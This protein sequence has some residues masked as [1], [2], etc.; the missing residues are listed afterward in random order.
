MNAAL[1]KLFEDYFKEYM[2]LIPIMATF[3]GIHKYNHLY[4]NYLSEQ[5][6][7]KNKIFYKKYLNLIKKINKLDLSKKDIHHINVLK[8]RLEGD[9]ESY[10][11]PFDLLP[12]DH[13][14]N[15]IIDHIETS[16]G[17][18]FLPLKTNKDFKNL[19]SQ[20]RSFF[21]VIDSSI[22]KM[23][24]GISKD[25]VFSKIIM[26]KT[27]KQLKNVIKTKNYLVSPSKI[28][29]NL[30][31]EYLE[32]MDIQFTLKIK[33][34]IK[35]LENEY[36]D[37]C[38]DDL[39]YP[40]GPEVYKYL[41]KNYT[42]LKNPNIPKIHK[43]GL[44]EVERINGEIDVLFLTNNMKRPTNNQL[45]K[46]TFKSKSNI[47]NDYE[48]VRKIINEKIIPKYFNIKISHDYL[49][50]KVPEFKEDSD[51]GAYYRMCSI[52]NKRKGTFFLNMS[53]VEDHQ[54]YSTLSL[55]LHEGNPGHHFQLTY[56]NDL[57][58]PNF[59]SYCGDEI[60]YVE[61]WALYAESL[62]HDFFKDSKDEKDI[63]FRFGCYNYEMMRACRLVVDTGIHYYGW[64]FK[65]CFDYM[66][67]NTTFSKKEIENEIYRYVAYAGQALAYK[68]GELKFKEL[69]E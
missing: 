59:I 19:I 10:K 28:P 47:I 40:G 46:M 32:V 6:I 44:D 41:V 1:K 14:N 27:L 15:F 3:I 54:T 45:R 65:K 20:T 34:M 31:D 25:I 69:K 39:R 12:I 33:K 63:M 22:C 48:R 49:L 61:G 13:F 35:F 57:D 67:Q 62:A 8:S 42:T 58:L 2:E 21:E 51:A 66:K 9:L 4:P 38:S 16:S 30:K 56:V 50:K 43:L 53:D 64:D 52:D 60:A 18:S 29:N 37:N 7:V 17:K 36:I 26:K 11:Y 55:S 24:E 5:E 68:I 23:R